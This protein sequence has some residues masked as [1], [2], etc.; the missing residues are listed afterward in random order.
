MENKST[1]SYRLADYFLC[2]S[3]TLTPATT[4]PGEDSLTLE[5]AYRYPS[6]DY[7]DTQMHWASIPMVTYMHLTK[8]SF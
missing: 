4:S 1:G 6:N 5:I 7:A 2:I 8:I 3:S